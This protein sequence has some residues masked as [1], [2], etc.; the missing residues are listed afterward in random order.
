MGYISI[1]ISN[2]RYGA[3]PVGVPFSDTLDVT[4][5]CT[6]TMTDNNGIPGIFSSF[7][8]RGY[9]VAAGLQAPSNQ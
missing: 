1:G 9:D 3:V 6:I 4:V 8:E 2:R 7:M 5:A